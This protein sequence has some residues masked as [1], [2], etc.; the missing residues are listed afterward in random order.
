MKYVPRDI[1]HMVLVTGEELLTE[2]VGEDQIEFLI[3]NPLRVNKERMLVKGVP[4][5]ANYF[6][7]WMGFADNPEFIIS[8]THIVAEALVDDHVAQY[9]NKMMANIEQDD[10]INIAEPQEA[11]HPEMLATDEEDDGDLPTF[12]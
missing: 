2:V 4:R 11:A 3:R 8:K 7:R 6:T 10:S 12:H 9:Y 5:E 1:R